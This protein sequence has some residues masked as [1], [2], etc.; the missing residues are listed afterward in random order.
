[1]PSCFSKHQSGPIIVQFHNEL[2]QNLG[3]PM[4]DGMLQ[5][6]SF[7]MRHWWLKISD[8]LSIKRGNPCLHVSPHAN[9][10]PSCHTLDTLWTINASHTL[11]ILQ[12]H[13]SHTLATLQPHFGLSMLATLLQY[14]SHTLDYQGQPQSSHT[15]AT[16]QPNSSHTLAKLS[17]NSFGLAML[18]TFSCHTLD[19][20]CQP[21]SSHNLDYQCQPH[22]SPTLTTLWTINASHHQKVYSR[23]ISG[24]PMSD[25]GPAHR[26]TFPVK[27]SSYSVICL[28]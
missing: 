20:Q 25:I 16:L 3:Q 26:V 17:P 6:V 1:M 5:P 15:S 21:H 22:S 27:M 2:F 24:K 7:M 19:Y 18:A 4:K 14:S 13:S 12:P 8:H 23:Y 10:A 28:R 9:Q 11:A